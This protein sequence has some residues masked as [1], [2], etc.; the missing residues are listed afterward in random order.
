[1]L[2]PGEKQGKFF[3]VD[4]G[5]SSRYKDSQT[6]EHISEN[7]SKSEPRAIN[8]EFSSLRYNRGE[9]V[10]RRDD[11]ESLIYLMLYWM[12][13]SLPWSETARNPKKN[14]GEKARLVLKLK[15]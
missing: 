14:E 13:G 12:K 8:M 15:Q 6:F 11:L 3:L 4:F 7:A 2:G 9:T 10:S 5:A 1:M